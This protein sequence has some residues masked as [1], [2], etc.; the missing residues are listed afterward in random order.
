M[1]RSKKDKKGGHPW[2]GYNRENSVVKAF[3]RRKRRQEGKNF[4]RD[5]EI[6]SKEPK[7]HK[8]SGGWFTW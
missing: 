5:Y 3:F 8:S 2:P 6:E 7:A 1:S 4:V